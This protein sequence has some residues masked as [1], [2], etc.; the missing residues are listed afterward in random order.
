M[1]FDQLDFFISVAETDTFLNAAEKLHISQSSLSK[2]IQK[3]ENEL[4]IKLLDRSKRSATLTKAGAAFYQEAL[5]LS[6]Q[7]QQTLKKMQKYR[8]TIANE[9]RIGT[10]PILA[11]YHLT[12]LIK[13]FSFQHPEIHLSISE[14]EEQ[15]L[16]DNLENN[17]DL[18]IARRNMF[19]SHSYIFHTLAS[20]RLC[21]ILPSTHPLALKKM[22]SIHE[23][24]NEKFLLMKPYTSIYQLCTELFEAAG[25]TPEIIRTSRME[26]IISAVSVKEGIG[27]LPEKNFHL[28]QHTNTVSVPLK[29]SPLLS[30]VVAYKKESSP[31][32]S[33]H[34]F[35]K[36]L[37]T[38]ICNNLTS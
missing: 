38:S 9:I 31:S 13:N 15:E 4:D 17:F 24:C 28:F 7:Y 23:I 19:D 6:N 36:Y 32:I 33:T 16:I 20:D 30:I 22:I 1:T 14:V 12:S 34:K 29:E 37:N 27:L 5:Q 35:L 11:Q 8:E 3:L 2:Q 21:V 25:V 18:I 10:L 26:S